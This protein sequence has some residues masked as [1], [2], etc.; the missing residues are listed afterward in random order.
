MNSILRRRREMMGLNQ[1]WKPLTGLSW[2][3]GETLTAEGHNSTSKYGSRT[4]YININ[5][6]P[7]VF[8]N[9]SA[10]K[11]ANDKNLN[12]SIHE[13]SGTTWL[14]RTLMNESYVSQN[15]REV[16]LGADCTRYR[17]TFN[18]PS[19]SGQTM[20]QEIVDTYFSAEY[21]EG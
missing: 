13:Y 14:R 20:T 9:N 4:G 5:S 7:Y 3:I 15:G 1:N 2:T 16:T 10:I 21:K 12:L 11:D 6:H 19:T 18:Y 17:L 8:K